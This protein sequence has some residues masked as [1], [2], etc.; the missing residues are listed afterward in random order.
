MPDLAVE[1]VTLVADEAT[2]VLEL[3]HTGTHTGVL[4]L[5]DG[6]RA[7]LGTDL[8]HVPPTGRDV[9]THGVVVLH[10]TDGSVAL[11]RHHWPPLWLYETL[12]LL[13]RP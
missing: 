10:V 1:P 12:G 11:E 3:R 8:D 4:A 5:D 13:P 6:G 2:A 9:A 7:L